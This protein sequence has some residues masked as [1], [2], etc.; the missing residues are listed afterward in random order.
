MYEPGFY[1][2]SHGDCYVYGHHR[3]PLAAVQPIEYVVEAKATVAFVVSVD[4]DGTARLRGGD[5]SVTKDD[6]NGADVRVLYGTR[7]N[8]LPED[9]DPIIDAIGAGRAGEL[10]VGVGLDWSAKWTPPI[11]DAAPV[12]P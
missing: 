5:Y 6:L 12:E 8:D 3:H 2:G 1:F 11:L 10:P 7:W 4:T 9:Q